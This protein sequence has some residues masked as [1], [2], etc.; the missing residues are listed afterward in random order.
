MME[1]VKPVLKW[2][3]GKTQILDDVLKHFPSYMNN[4]HE[5]F[6]G[7]GSVLFGLL[8]LVYEGK[9]KI[10]GNIYASDK[11]DCLIHMYKNIQD[12][13]QDVL[14]ELQDIVNEYNAL[15]MKG[16]KESLNRNPVDK[17][18]ALVCQE[19]YYYWIRKCFNHLKK[20]DKH[21]CKASAYFI[22][23]NKTCF[24]GIYREGPNGFNVPF[25]NYKN[26]SIYD[27]DHI[28]IVSSLLQNVVFTTQDFSNTFEI[29]ED[30]DFIY[31]DP[32]YA[33]EKSTSFVSYTTDGFSSTFNKK[34]FDLCNDV[35]LTRKVKFIMSNSNVDEVTKEFQSDKYNV[36]V[37]YCKRSINSKNPSAKT[38]EVLIISE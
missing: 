2:V 1:V 23:L 30:N 4:Y 31:L 38:K 24:R 20:E 12:R 9:I 26:P 7:G 13:P 34:L 27:E 35:S 3:G 11:N 5:P 32:P 6:I 25:G 15:P 36:I 14:S 33:V 17:N 28:F 29:L 22:F 8:S 19:T 18:E 10:D 16:N 21:S 37:L